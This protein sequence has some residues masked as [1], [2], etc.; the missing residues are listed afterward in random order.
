MELSDFNLKKNHLTFKRLYHQVQ[1]TFVIVFFQHKGNIHSVNTVFG[2][3][4]HEWFPFL[5]S[6]LSM[7]HLSFLNIF[8]LKYYNQLEN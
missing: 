1:V 3:W 5:F 7:Y 6:V 8:T 4:A 2:Q